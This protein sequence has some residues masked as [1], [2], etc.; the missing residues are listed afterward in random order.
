MAPE[1]RLSRVYTMFLVSCAAG[2]IVTPLAIAA[3][4]V[5]TLPSR[6]SLA[7]LAA[8]A[9]LGLMPIAPRHKHPA[10]TRFFT[11]V[12]TA[13]DSWFS[14]RVIYNKEKFTHAGPHV[15]GTHPFPPLNTASRKQARLA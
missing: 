12:A 13:A 4:A 9:V 14:L 15:I 6:W 5:V 3:L 10:I 11:D 1:R 2:C 8:L 7:A